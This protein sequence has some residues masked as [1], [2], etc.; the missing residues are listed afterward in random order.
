MNLREK[1]AA[2]VAALKRQGSC[3]NAVVHIDAQVLLHA[4]DA[5]H[6]QLVY[7]DTAL[8]YIRENYPMVYAECGDDFRHGRAVLI[9]PEIRN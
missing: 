9:Q 3:V 6:W 4:L 2:S 1:V 5:A 7:A 8:N